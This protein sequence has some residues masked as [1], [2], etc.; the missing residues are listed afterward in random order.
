MRAVRAAA[1]TARADSSDSLESGGG[2]GGVGSAEAAAA[3]AGRAAWRS[4]EDVDWGEV[5]RNATAM[6][7]DA[8]A[9]AAAAL[10]GRMPRRRRR[11][12]PCRSLSRL[13]WCSLLRAPLE[14][15]PAWMPLFHSIVA[16]PAP[17]APRLRYTRASRRRAV[18]TACMMAL[19]R[20]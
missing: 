15:V 1:S 20:W 8:A 14:A 18:A 2:V 12:P 6:P 10:P 19:A 3:A 7:A 5:L 11:H 13:S 16:G 9:A 17:V 4:G